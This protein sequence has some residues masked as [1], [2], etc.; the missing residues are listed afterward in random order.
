MIFCQATTDISHL[1]AF[2]AIMVLPWN[3]NQ[4]I[5]QINIKVIVGFHKSEKFAGNEFQKSEWIFLCEWAWSLIWIKFEFYQKDKTTI[6]AA[7]T[8][9]KGWDFLEYTSE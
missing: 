8:V 5:F 6:Y 3:Q 9:A 4:H 1:S 7:D 2:I